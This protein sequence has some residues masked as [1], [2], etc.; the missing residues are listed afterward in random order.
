M[1][2]GIDLVFG[3]DLADRNAIHYMEVISVEDTAVLSWFCRDL[4]WL[5]AT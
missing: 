3:A 1:V 4:K 2:L 5:L